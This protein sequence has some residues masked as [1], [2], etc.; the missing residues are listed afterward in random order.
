MNEP[1]YDHVDRCPNC[2]IIIDPSFFTGQVKWHCRFEFKAEVQFPTV[3]KSNNRILNDWTSEDQAAMLAV[4]DKT[5]KTRVEE[6]KV[7]PE[8]VF[9]FITR[10]FDPTNT[11]H[12]R[13]WKFMKETARW[14]IGFIPD[15]T[16]FPPGWEYA[17]TSVMAYRLVDQ[18][19]ANEYVASIP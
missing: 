9:N 1:K 6:L 16:T 2:Q 4:I 7:T 11:H 12:L 13:A 19:I 18:A 17:L 14:P 3:V 15:W 8:S 5:C 10:W